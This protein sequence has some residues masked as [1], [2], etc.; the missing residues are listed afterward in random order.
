MSSGNHVRR[1]ASVLAPLFLAGCLG[2][3]TSEPRQRYY[4][5]APTVIETTAAVAAS[6]PQ[7][8]LD[9]VDARGI[10]AERPLLYR[11]AGESAPLEQY[12]YASW[13]EPPDVML[14]DALLAD[15]GRA[16]GAT[17]VRRAPVRGA[18]DI[19]IGVRVQALEQ[20]IDGSRAQAH[21]AAVYTVAD[22]AGESLLV[23][24]YDRQ[25][26][27]VGLSPLEFVKALDGLA[28]E[29]DRALIDK[30]R[31]LPGTKKRLGGEAQPK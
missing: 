6:G 20:I 23:Y 3:G 16:F 26:D 17:N 9:A 24:R 14:E 12:A 30:L 18:P 5:I 13:A 10:Y 25:S 4:S 19:R 21:F 15:L 2:G 1:A 7:I 22:A 28:A 31:T 8:A 29:A 27:A 11:T